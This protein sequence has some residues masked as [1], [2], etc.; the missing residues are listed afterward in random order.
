[1]PSGD[2]GTYIANNQLFPQN[3]AAGG[4]YG[5]Y[6]EWQKSRSNIEEEIFADMFLGWVFNKWAAD[7]AGRR[8]A[9]YMDNYMRNWQALDTGGG[10]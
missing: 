7:D 3:R 4:F 8:R 5:N 9:T 2:L 6:P 10:R 1:M